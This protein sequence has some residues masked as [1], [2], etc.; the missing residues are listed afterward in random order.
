V[1]TA[2]PRGPA[3]TKH[4]A[5]TTAHPTRLAARLR[6]IPLGRI[7]MP[8]D[9]AGLALFPALPLAALIC[10]EMLP[11]NRRLMPSCVL[12]LRPVARGIRDSVTFTC[13]PVTNAS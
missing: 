10:G 2:S 6:K 3:A 11:V 12:G 9:V 5:A 8:E 13:N 4:I 1:P 7:G